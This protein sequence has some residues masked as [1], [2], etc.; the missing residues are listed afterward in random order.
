MEAV[1]CSAGQCEAQPWEHISE[2]SKDEWGGSNS[3][4]EVRF[5]IPGAHTTACLHTDIPA[6]CM[7]ASEGPGMC[8][9]ARGVFVYTCT[10]W[11]VCFFIQ[12]NV[13]KWTYYIP[14][15]I[16]KHAQRSLSRQNKGASYFSHV[17]YQGGKTH[18]D[19][20]RSWLSQSNQALI[21]PRMPF[22]ISSEGGWESKRAKEKNKK[23]AGLLV[24]SCEQSCWCPWNTEESGEGKPLQL[25]NRPCCLLGCCAACSILFQRK[26]LG[27]QKWLVFVIVQ[28]FCCDFN[29][30]EYQSR[31]TRWFSLF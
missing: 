25:L 9:R 2:K 23:T 19:V 4:P 7:S 24:V 21:T 18:T 1:K 6:E 15:H 22:T 28:S 31:L 12:T 3:S 27:K 5:R 26:S 11:S 30:N 29:G 8:V 10:W 13:W 14:L 16:I 20:E 17:W